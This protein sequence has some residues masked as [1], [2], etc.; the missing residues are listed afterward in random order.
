MT[1]LQKMSML[2]TLLQPPNTP[3]AIVANAGDGAV[4]RFKMS[5]YPPDH[6]TSGNRSNQS[7]EK[8]GVQSVSVNASGLRRKKFEQLSAEKTLV[9]VLRD[10]LLAL[11]YKPR[12]TSG[13][14]TEM[15]RGSSMG[16]RSLLSS[17]SP[18]R[19]PPSYML[20]LW[21]MGVPG[22]NSF[23]MNRRL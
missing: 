16:K 7:R 9:R 4:H 3:E 6:R 22:G 10:G 8:T 21:I 12:E 20:D 18:C 15:V 1:C 14:Q 19:A 5:V 2:A 17:E 23:F 13:G 11:P